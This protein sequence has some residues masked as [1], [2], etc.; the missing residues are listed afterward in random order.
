MK[1]FPK[2]IA[3]RGAS[4]LAPEN[5]L[6]AFKKAIEL[7][8][9]GIELDVH[10][11]KDNE[12]VVIHDFFLNRTTDGSGLVANHTLN[13]LKKLDAGIYFSP[14]FKGTKIPT[15]E[16]VFKLVKPYKNLEVN[17][18]IKI[19]KHDYIGIEQKIIELI[20]K[21]SFENRAIVISFNKNSI[22]KVKELNSKIKT[23]ILFYMT[24][25]DPIKYYKNKLSI[26]GLYSSIKYITF[27]K[28]FFKLF[29]YRLKKNNL[30]IYIF[31]IDSEN[32]MKFLIKREI[33]GIITNKPDKLYKLKQQLFGK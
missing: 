33:N 14:E 8:C 19:G 15:L 2:I 4:S 12:M 30:F 29:L 10:L 20:H 31:T 3:H 23:G 6:P 7:H 27:K 16:E 22:K 32:Q 26:N 11:S 1:T 17:I 25:K 9:D 13:E 21:Y 28:Y 5:T 24:L 18:E